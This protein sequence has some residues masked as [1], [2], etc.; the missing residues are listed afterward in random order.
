[1]T[2]EFANGR[3]EIIVDSR[4]DMDVLLEHAVQQLKGTA[5]QLKDR[6][7]MITRHSASNFTVEFHESVP[8]GLT[9]ERQ[10]KW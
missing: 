7:I 2:E 3:L 1:M 6:G 4:E 10:E 5:R 9:Q 8:F